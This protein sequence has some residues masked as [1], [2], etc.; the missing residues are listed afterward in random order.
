MYETKVTGCD[1]GEDGVTV[2]AEAGGKQQAGDDP[3]N[4]F[5]LETNE[6]RLPGRAIDFQHTDAADD[7]HK[8]EQHPVKIPK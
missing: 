6:F 8:A 5:L 2:R 4:L 1:K 7:Q 3:V